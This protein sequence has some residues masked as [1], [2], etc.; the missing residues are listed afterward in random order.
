[1]YWGTADIDAELARVLALGAKLGAPLQ[2][3][4]GGIRVVMVDDPF[5]NRVGLIQ[6]PHF[7]PA[8]VK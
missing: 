7:D 2:D 4:G 6:N 5:G 3:V 1:V 8:A